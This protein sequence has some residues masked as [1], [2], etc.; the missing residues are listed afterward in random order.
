MATSQFRLRK[1]EPVAVALAVDTAQG[2]ADS[3]RLADLLRRSGAAVT[4]EWQS[5]GHELTPQDING[6][7]RWLEPLI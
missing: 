4:V 3:E 5:G 2:F 7:R 1:V 6:A